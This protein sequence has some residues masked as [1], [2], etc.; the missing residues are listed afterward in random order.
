MSR[1]PLPVYEELTPEQQNA[2]RMIAGQRDGVVN[3]PFPAWIRMPALCKEIQDVSDI[4]RTNT[5]LKKTVFEM[6]TL[7]VARA[8]N[9]GYMWGAH[10]GFAVELGLPQ[11]VIDD[12][13]T[14]RRPMLEDPEDQLIFDVAYEIAAGRPVPI[15]IY[16]KAVEILGYERLTEV[17]TDVGFYLMIACVSNTYDVQ[18]TSGALP[19]APHQA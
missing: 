8:F 19:L 10:A 12:I 9:S 3:G 11:A 7:I 17:A 18:P 14:G 15:D 5:T 4:L 1:L 13:N 16:T 6:L 2:F